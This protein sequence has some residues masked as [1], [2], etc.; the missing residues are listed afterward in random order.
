MPKHPFELILVPEEN[1]LPVGS[2]KILLS[3]CLQEEAQFDG[4]GRPPGE[5]QIQDISN[6]ATE[7]VRFVKA[8]DPGLLVVS[9][10]CLK[11]PLVDNCPD[12]IIRGFL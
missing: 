4:F 2:D 10:L 8:E 11:I 12:L 7:L 5:H 3:L 6:I 1:P 9:A